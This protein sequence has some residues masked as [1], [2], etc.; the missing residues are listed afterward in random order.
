MFFDDSIVHRLT[1]P[2]CFKSQCGVDEL[3]K[4]EFRSFNKREKNIS[5]SMRPKK[6]K[7]SAV[8]GIEVVP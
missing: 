4:R 8:D 3:G 6:F 5:V 2:Y 1:P 7:E